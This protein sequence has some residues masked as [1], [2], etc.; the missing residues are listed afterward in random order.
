MIYLAIPYTGQEELSYHVATHI[1]AELSKRGEVVFSPITHSHPFTKITDLPGD[2]A[3]WGKIDREFIE[4]SDQMWIVCMDGWKESVGV[5]HE[6]RIA[7]AAG[8]PIHKLNVYHGPEKSFIISR[9]EIW[10]PITVPPMEAIPC[11]L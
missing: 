9:P 1:T 3:F 8:I 2:W 11:E 6:Q 7:K 5:G 4:R 10:K